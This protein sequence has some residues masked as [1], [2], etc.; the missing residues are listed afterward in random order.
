MN[1]RPMAIKKIE[2]K[3]DGEKADEGMPDWMV[4]IVMMIPL[5]PFLG[6]SAGIAYRAFMVFSGIGG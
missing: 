1:T 4:T 6:A 2:Q 3:I 5:I